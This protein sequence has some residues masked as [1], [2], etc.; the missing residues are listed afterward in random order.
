MWKWIE[1]NKVSALCILITPVLL[2]GSFFGSIAEKH[3]IRPYMQAQADTVFVKKHNLCEAIVFGKIGSVSEAQKLDR[4][5]IIKMYYNQKA[6][7]TPK[8]EE[9]ARDLMAADTSFKKLISGK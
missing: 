5:F 7:M 3:F 6:T 1:K 8:E 2:V 9:K 4:E